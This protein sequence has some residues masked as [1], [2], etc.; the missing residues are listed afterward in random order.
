MILTQHQMV[1]IVRTL[2]GRRRSQSRKLARLPESISI[3][4][5]PVDDAE[6][7][8]HITLPHRDKEQNI[9]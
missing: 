4:I 2:L 5:Y 1:D 7:T 9:W 8:M 6:N 3:L